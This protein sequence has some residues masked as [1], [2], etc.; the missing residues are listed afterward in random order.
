MQ[1]RERCSTGFEYALDDPTTSRNLG[2]TPHG[3]M[4]VSAGPKAEVAAPP[5]G[6]ADGVEYVVG[7]V[8]L[9]DLPPERRGQPDY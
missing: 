1:Q 7:G 4:R 6:L 3:D 8:G 9:L 2:Y 5:L